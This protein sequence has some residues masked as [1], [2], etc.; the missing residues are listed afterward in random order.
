[1]KSGGLHNVRKSHFFAVAAIAASFGLFAGQAQAAA[2][3][4][5]GT[6][7]GGL[8]VAFGGGVGNFINACPVGVCVFST[9]FGAFTT[10]V[11]ADGMSISGFGNETFVENNGVTTSAWFSITNIVATN[12]GAAADSDNL[13]LISDWFAPSLAATAGVGIIGSFINGG[14]FPG[15]STQAQMNYLTTPIGAGIPAGFSLTTAAVTVP[16]GAPSPLPFVT[17]VFVNGPIVGVEQLVGVVN[18]SLNPGDSEF[19]PGSLVIEENDPASIMDDAPEPGTFALF[20]GALAGLAIL[21]R[22]RA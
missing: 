20:G 10:G 3:G 19:L 18:F 1:M 9:G 8:F 11:M 5:A 21:R 17:S 16:G 14:G 7:T 2:V 13:Y 22:K 6:A 4:I 12:F 15:D